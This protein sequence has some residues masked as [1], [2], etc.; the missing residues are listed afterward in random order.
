MISNIFLRVSRTGKPPPDI[1][2]WLNDKLLE[3]HELSTTEENVKISEVVIRN[4]SRNH[5]NNALICESSNNDF[6]P[7]LSATIYLDVYRK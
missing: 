1:K 3:S 2:W 5:F 4:L 7:P 6:N